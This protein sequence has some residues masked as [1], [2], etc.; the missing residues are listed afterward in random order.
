[1]AT[2]WSISVCLFLLRLSVSTVDGCA[3]IVERSEEVKEVVQTATG[4][5]PTPE[6]QWKFVGVWSLC[7]RH[8]SGFRPQWRCTFIG[9]LCQ[10]CRRFW[11]DAHSLSAGFLQQLWMDFCEI[12]ESFRLHS[13]NSLLDLRTVPQN[14][15]FC[16]PFPICALVT[17]AETAEAAAEVIRVLLLSTSRNCVVREIT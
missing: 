11:W 9:S 3:C 10:Q 6:R 16:A 1:M 17:R 15:V 8:A 14:L 5:S 13:T 4:T 2:K 7:S 12:W